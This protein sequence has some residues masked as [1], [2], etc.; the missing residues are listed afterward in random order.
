MTINQISD[1]HESGTPLADIHKSALHTGQ[2]SY[3][4]TLINVSDSAFAAASFK[5]HFLQQPLLNNTDT[6]FI[7]RDTDQQLLSHIADPQHPIHLFPYPA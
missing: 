6:G 7:V 2:D 5:K 4:F 1:V 3:D